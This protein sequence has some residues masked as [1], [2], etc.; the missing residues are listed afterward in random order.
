MLVLIDMNYRR[1]TRGTMCVMGGLGRFQRQLGSPLK[2]RRW[3]G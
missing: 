1:I 3:L 2:S